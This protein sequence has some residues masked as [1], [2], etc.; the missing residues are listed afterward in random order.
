MALRQSIGR[1]FNLA[2]RPLPRT[3]PSA[4]IHRTLSSVRN[5]RQ[6]QRRPNPKF[7]SHAIRILDG[8]YSDGGSWPEDATKEYWRKEDEKREESMK[9]DPKIIK[10]MELEQEAL[11]VKQE[12]DAREKKWIENAKP[13]VRKVEI[14]HRGRSYGR[15]G[16]KCSTARVWI[17]PGEGVITI[18][19][20]EFLDYFPR[21]TDRE[22]IL[23]PFIA[24]NTCGM[25]DMVVR[26][27]SGGVTGKAGAIRHGLARALEKYNPD[28]RPPMKRLGFMTRD[29]RVVES[30]KVGKK[31]ARKAPQWVRR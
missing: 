7:R 3:L 27:E 22:M 19:R 20:R 25:F 29:R 14:D 1:A 6:Q 16:R 31:K 2:L 9:L 21:E 30:K 8:D 5:Q 11:R 26:V 10:E 23:S 24:T 13:K 28:Y 15:G 12:I 17:Q 18:N 4:P